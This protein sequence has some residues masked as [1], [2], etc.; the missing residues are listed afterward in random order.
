MTYTC[1]YLEVILESFIG[2]SV[3]L[4]LSPSS[5]DISGRWWC[6]KVIGLNAMSKDLES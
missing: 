1:D 4:H 3:P 2:F 5:L 6:L